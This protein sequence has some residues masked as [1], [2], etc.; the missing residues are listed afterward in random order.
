M[1]NLKL[2][3]LTGKLFS[4]ECSAIGMICP[5]EDGNELHDNDMK[6]ILDLLNVFEL[7]DILSMLK[8]V[9]ISVIQS[10]CLFCCMILLNFLFY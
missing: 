1:P 10:L 9:C 3:L 6:H 2:K 4:F 7:R 8:K 5:F